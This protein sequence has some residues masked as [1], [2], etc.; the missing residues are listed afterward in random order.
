MVRYDAVRKTPGTGAVSSCCQ[1]SCV[2]YVIACDPYLALGMRATGRQENGRDAQQDLK[3]YSILRHP[4]HK[5]I[6]CASAS[7]HCIARPS[8][9]IAIGV[10]RGSQQQYVS[11]SARGWCGERA[12]LKLQN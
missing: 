9:A 4:I 8:A 2:G 3:C 1:W 10:A 5:H 12:F 7:M 6:S 11:E